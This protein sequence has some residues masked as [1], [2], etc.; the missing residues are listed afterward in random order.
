AARPHSRAAPGRSTP[1]SGWAH[2]RFPLRGIRLTN[3]PSL[4]ARWPPGR[5]RRAGTQRGVH[6]GDQLVYSDRTAAVAVKGETGTQR[7]RVQVDVDTDDQ[8]VD[9]YLPVTIAVADTRRERCGWTGWRC[10]RRRR[11]RAHRGGGGRG[12]TRSDA[13]ERGCRVRG[14]S[15]N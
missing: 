1:H 8:L 4:V 15:S 5:T 13:G 9:R 10:G 7:R 11:W 6:R 12:I 2:G 3:P 14:Q